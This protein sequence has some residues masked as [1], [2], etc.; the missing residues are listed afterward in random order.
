MTDLSNTQQM[1]A[2]V[3]ALQE[4]TAILESLSARLAF[5]FPYD[6]E[7]GG[8]IERAEAWRQYENEQMEKRKLWKERRDQRL[9]EEA[10]NQGMPSSLTTSSAST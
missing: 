1:G 8:K 7:P 6:D 10:A 5:A 4:Q 3:T 2:I 9:R